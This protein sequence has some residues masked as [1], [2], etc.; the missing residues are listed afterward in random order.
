MENKAVEDM[1]KDPGGD[2]WYKGKMEGIKRRLS[3]LDKIKFYMKNFL[4]EKDK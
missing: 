3:L 4:H 1:A 2:L